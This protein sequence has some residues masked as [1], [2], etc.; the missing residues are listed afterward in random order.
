MRL[1]EFPGSFTD[2]KRKF[3]MS[4][5]ILFIG[6]SLTEWG[7]WDELFPAINIVNQG[8]AGDKTADI[9]KRLYSIECQADMVFMMAGVND[10]GDN[11]SNILI[12]N[13]I[14]EILE[15][16]K[17]L[18]PKALV[19]S[20]SILPVSRERAKDA[21]SIKNIIELN[22]KIADIS[23]KAECDFTDMYPFFSDEMGYMNRD[24]SADGLHLNQKGYELWASLIAPK[25]ENRL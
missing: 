25:I 2:M 20:Y 22:K 8:K 5:T 4:N 7:N 23:E 24:F 16:L 3:N 18:F 14:S 1:R 9:L 17:S 21:L 12:M 6:D 15:R 11:L 19:H 13:N 10:L